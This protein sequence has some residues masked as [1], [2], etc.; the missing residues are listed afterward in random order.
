MQVIKSINRTEENADRIYKNY[1]SLD[2]ANEGIA[3]LRAKAINVLTLQAADVFLDNR[4]AILEG[5][6]NDALMD[7]IENNSGAL[8]MVK[9]VSIEEIYNH[10]IVMQ[11]EIAGYNVMSELLQLFIPALVKAKPA[12][13]DEKILNLFPY[14]FTE[15]K[16]TTSKYLRVMSALDFLSGMTDVFATELYRRLKGIVIPEHG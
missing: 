3:F 13:K 10:P 15:F 14:Q 2:D 5:N 9:K 7:S 16:E 8:K 6:F 4:Q 12:H 1:K 11:I